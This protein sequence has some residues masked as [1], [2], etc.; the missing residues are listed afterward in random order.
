MNQEAVEFISMLR[1]AVQAY[2][3]AGCSSRSPTRVNIVHTFLCDKIRNHLPEG[4]SVNLEQNV[5]AVNAA[6]RKKCDIVISKG[7]TPHVVF[8]VKF[9]MGNYQQNKNNYFENLTGE[10]CHLKWA[11]GINICPINIAFNKIPYRNNQ[12]IITKFE[13]MEYDKTL[14]VYEQLVNNGLCEN[15]V[16]YIIGVEWNNVI[17][18]PITQAP[19][20]NGFN[21]RTPYVPM[22]QLLE[23]LL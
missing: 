3:A 11:T 4:Y 21:K 5:L 17:G 14:S 13:I 20:I 16:N 19:I 1:V 7:S 10:L 18:E 6:G 15:I 8:P 22:G 9:I 12:K 23:K 2:M